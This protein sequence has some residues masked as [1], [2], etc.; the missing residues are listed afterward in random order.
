M[1]KNIIYSNQSD[2]IFHE[3]STNDFDSNT[4]RNFET[5]I[6]RIKKN[7]EDD[8]QLNWF[9]S[10]TKKKKLYPYRKSLFQVKL[11]DI[12]ANASHHKPG[13]DYETF[14][15]RNIEIKTKQDFYVNDSVPKVQKMIKE[16][17]NILALTQKLNKIDEQSNLSKNN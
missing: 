12:P 15:S 5:N 3:I 7:F 10:A 14:T 4:A 16:K 11:S 17:N 6:K 13:L 2:E 1:L 9:K 8:Q